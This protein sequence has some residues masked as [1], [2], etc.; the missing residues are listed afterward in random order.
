MHNIQYDL[1][2]DTNVNPYYAMRQ[3]M[4]RA[5]VGNEAAG[6]DPTVNLLL[7]RVCELLGK[8]AAVFMPT[9]TMCSGVAYRALCQPGERIIIEK[10]AHPL[11]I[12]HRG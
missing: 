5:K 12:W 4:S 3:M 2:S 6:E 9:G 10:T 8:P 7:A 1:F 11:K